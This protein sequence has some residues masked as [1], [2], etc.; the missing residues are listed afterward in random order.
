MGGGDS[1][2]I[3]FEDIRVE[4]ATTATSFI[5]LGIK[6]PW[7]PEANY[8]QK[9]GTGQLNHH[10]FKNISIPTLGI[11]MLKGFNEQYQVHNIHLENITVA[12]KQ[13]T[14]DE[15]KKHLTIGPFVHSVTL[16]GQEVVP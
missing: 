2:F 13:L 11:S 12:G 16:D 1:T 5:K 14:V 9:S 8:K 10:Y 3:T 7:K 4:D 6:A 15:W